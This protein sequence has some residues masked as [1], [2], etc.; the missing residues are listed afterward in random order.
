MKNLRQEEQLTIVNDWLK[1]IVVGLDLC[2]FAKKPF[3]NDQIRLKLSPHITANEWLQDFVSELDLLNKTP[4][5]K[6]S[7][8]LL[9]LPNAYEEFRDFHDFVGSLEEFLEENQLDH[10]FQLVSFHPTFIFDGLDAQE[11]GH[12]VNRSPFPIIHILR[13]EEIALAIKTI[14]DGENISL[15]NDAKL[16]HMSQSSFFKKFDYLTKVT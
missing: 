10:L 2:P 1:E 9:I 7:T 16:N 12:F 5:E 6:L 8:T 3:E 14:Q 4:K 15:K 13:S 11:R